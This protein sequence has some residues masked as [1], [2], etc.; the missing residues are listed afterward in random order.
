MR[1]LRRLS[2]RHPYAYAYQHARTVFIHIP[3]TSSGAEQLR[4]PGNPCRDG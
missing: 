1:V 2:K 3:A 4:K